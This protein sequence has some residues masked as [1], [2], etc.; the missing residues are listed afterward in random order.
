MTNLVLLLLLGA[1]IGLVLE[2]LLQSSFAQKVRERKELDAYLRQQGVSDLV[3]K[4]KASRRGQDGISQKEL[5]RIG[6]VLGGVD[7]LVSAKQ[8]RMALLE[9]FVN[10]HVAPLAVE[11]PAASTPPRFAEYLLY[12][13]LPKRSRD[14]MLGDL[15]EEYY[16]A[17]RRYGYRYAQVFYWSQVVRSLWPL[18]AAL[19]Q[20]ALKWGVL[21]WLGHAIRRLIS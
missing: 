9:A 15:E 4:F 18:I 20:K 10:A 21:G 7:H 14:N 3:K 8:L 11:E 19:V 16:K 12:I 5:L 13:F 1:A 17:Y 6:K 2:G